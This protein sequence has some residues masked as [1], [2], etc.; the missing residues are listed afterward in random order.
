MCDYLLL[1]KEMKVHMSKSYTI[2]LLCLLLLAPHPSYGKALDVNFLF[3]T[4]Y[5]ENLST[6]QSGTGFITIRQ[7]EKDKYVWFLISNKHVLMPKPLE[8]KQTDKL[9][10]VARVSINIKTASDITKITREVILR[11][12][13]GTELAKGHTAKNVDVAGLIFTRYLQD[14]FATPDKRVLG[15]QEDRF[16]SE[17]F[18]KKHF[19]SVG[20][21]ALVIGYP[22]SL[23]DEG[24][25]IPI[26]R[27]VRIATKPD[28]DFRKQP[29]FLVDGTII[30]GTS[31]SPVILPIRPHVWKEEHKISV[32]EIQQNHLVGIIASS[33]KDWEIV[34]RKIV[35]LESTQE[36]SVIDN[37]NLGIVFK[38]RT[39]SEVMDLFG[40]QRWEKE[41]QEVEAPTAGGK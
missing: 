16:A 15:I 38:V 10:A 30:R 35:T 18:L 3:S 39:V 17:E 8:P 26:T 24:N 32:G 12:A 9:E 14:I 19:I 34:I 13:K 36:F 1:L 37:A 22:L 6:N 20:D 11:D 2:F 25:V 29:I 23:I 41:K 28:Y 31:G 4:V 33:I 40:Y 27:G 21:E 5:I 7:I